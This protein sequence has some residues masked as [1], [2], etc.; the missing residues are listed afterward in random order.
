MLHKELQNKIDKLWTDFW[1]GGI[2]NPLSVIE[3]ITFLIF[4][5]LLDI[6]ETNNEKIARRLGK[7][8]K[9]IFPQDKQYLR[10]SSFRH[11]G[12]DEMLK[13]VR[14]EVFPA[15]KDLATNGSTFGEYM[16]DAQLL[17]Q[18]PA[19]LVSA[20][21]TIEEL[22]LTNDDTKGD[23]YEY[24]LSKLTTAGI[25]GQFRTPR[26]IIELMVKITAPKPTEKV[27]D[28]ACGTAGFLVGVIQHLTKEYTSQQG[29]L[30]DDEGNKIYSGDLLEPYRDHIQQNLLTGFDFDASMLRIAAMNLMLHGIDSPNVHYEDT[31]SNAFREHYPL[32]ASDYF[33]VILANPPFKGSIDFDSV[34]PSLTGK[35]KTKKTELLFITLMLRML[36]LGGRCAAI[37]PDG[38][39]FG[40]SKAHVSLRKALIEENQLEG[41]ISLPSGVFKPYAGVSTAI[42][43]FTK[44]GATE[45]VWFYDVQADGYSLDD[46]RTPVEQNDL[47]DAFKK[48]QQRDPQKDSDRTQKNFFVPADEIRENNYDLSINR[49]KEIVYEEE[50]YEEPKVILTKLKKIENEIFDGLNEIE[51]ML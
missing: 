34:D 26:H 36:K 24:L 28:P 20:V 41:I 21:T 19:L 39:L 5:R 17:I 16:K 50:E 42:V 30:T 15:F 29:V 12:P 6:R 10:W 2:T 38:V 13:V 33:D 3:Q 1:S 18:K 14:D 7:S 9:R 8:F 35:V 11:L 37:V 49:Y 46:K 40:A 25:A 4:A 45:N 22:P 47:P 48:W 44:G 31:L 43:I 27:A 23:L 51:E 32:L